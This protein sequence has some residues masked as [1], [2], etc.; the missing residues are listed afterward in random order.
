[1]LNEGIDVLTSIIEYGK[2]FYIPIIS[3]FDD[4]ALAFR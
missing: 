4:A 2:Y 1:M 3:E